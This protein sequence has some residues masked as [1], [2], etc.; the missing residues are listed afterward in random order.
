[1]NPEKDHW[2]IPVSW[3][4]SGVIKVMK[5][6]CPTIKEAIAFVDDPTSPLPD[7]EDSYYIDDSFQVDDE[8]SIYV[9][10]PEVE[11]PYEN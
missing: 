8:E 6:D 7:A 11:N 1:M 5:E 4:M 10:N 9:N 3:S 2:V